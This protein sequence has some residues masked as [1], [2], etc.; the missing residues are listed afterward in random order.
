MCLEFENMTA[1]IYVQSHYFKLILDKIYIFWNLMLRNYIIVY[2]FETCQ[3][4][5]S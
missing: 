4:Q 5:H 3:S 2:I 1:S